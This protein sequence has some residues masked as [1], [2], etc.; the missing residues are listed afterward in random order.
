MFTFVTHI[1]INRRNIKF[2]FRTFFII[3]SCFH[4]DYITLFKTCKEIMVDPGNSFFLRIIHVFCPHRNGVGNVTIYAGILF[5]YICFQ[6]FLCLIDSIVPRETLYSFTINS[7][8]I[9]PFCHNNGC[10][11]RTHITT[12]RR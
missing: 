5:S 3:L 4:T 8:F 10:G 6:V 1:T 7:Y 12:L 2:T 9:I 11:S